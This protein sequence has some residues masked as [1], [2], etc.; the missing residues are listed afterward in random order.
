MNSSRRSIG[1]IAI[2]LICVLG[3]ALGAQA[4]APP[5]PPLPPPL[6]PPPPCD[7]T[8]LPLLGRA[9]EFGAM[10]VGANPLTLEGAAFAS[11]GNIGVGPLGQLE[12]KGAAG[13]VGYVK[14]HFGTTVTN[15]AAALGGVI[16]TDVSG[17]AAD[18]VAASN[19]FA[20]MAPT[21]VYGALTG[22]TTISGNGCINVINIMGDIDLNG[23]D[24]VRLQGTSEDY[25]V[26]N[27]FGRIRTNG[28][29][30]IVLDGM[31]PSHVLFNI[32]APG[33]DV[34]LQGDSGGNGTI[35][36][37]QG[38]IFLNGN[39]GGTGAYYVGGGDLYFLGNADYHGE[40]FGCG[41]PAC[42]DPEASGINIQTPS[43][44]PSRSTGNR[45]FFYAY[46]DP[47][48]L[49]GHLEAFRVAPNGTI[50]DE[51][52]VDAVDPVTNQLVAGRDYYWE[53]GEEL[54]LNA[55]R[56][57]YTTDGGNQE[58]FDN[59]VVDETDLNLL[60]GEI[61]AYPN[62][63]ASGVTTL[64]LLRDAI[65]QYA[66]GRDSFDE[67]GDLNF[68]ELRP[69][70]LGDIF[71]SNPVYIGEPTTLL[72]HEDG[73]AGDPGDFL[74][75]YRTRDHMV[76]A[77]ANDGIFHAF[78]AGDYY[79]PN[80]P[81]PAVFD[82]GDGSE[83]FGYIPGQLLDQIK[84][85]PR[86]ADLPGQRLAPGFVDGNIVAADAWIGDDAS[87]KTGDE[88]ATVM[89]TA[90]REGGDGYLAVDVTNPDAG[91]GDDHGPYPKLLWEFGDPDLGQSWS[92]PV[93][94]RV[95]LAAAPLSGDNCGND[96]GDGDCE[97]VWVAI[98]GG[99]YELDSDP[100]SRVNYVDDPASA[101]W[102]DTTK[103]IF[104]VRLDD[105]SILGKVEFDPT[106][107]NGPDKMVYA[108]AS[109]PAALDLDGDQF[110]DVVYIGDVGGQMWKWDI[111]ALG[112][113][114]DADNVI[115]NWDYG[116][117]FQTQPVLLSDGINSHYKSMFNPPAGALQNGELLIVVGTGMRNNVLYAGDAAVDDQNRVYV[118]RDANPTGPLA[119]SSVITEADLIDITASG[120]YI[121]T[122]A[123]KGY[124]FKGEE[125]EKFLSDPVIFAGFAIVPSYSP[126][127]WP[128]CGPG[129]ANLFLFKLY[130]ASGFWDQDAL[131]TASDRKVQIGWGIPSNPR[132]SIASD[133]SNDKIF[134]NTSNGEVLTITPP[135]RDNPGSETIYWKQNF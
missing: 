46:F 23:A 70:V 20:A 77:G 111:S 122:G 96:D 75:T 69:S 24:E 92:R 126:P 100:N 7:C 13:T 37:L 106:G 124:F 1:S 133:P 120:T 56:T 82:V 40:P 98:F 32:R 41:N 134:I 59:T 112:V 102:N 9:A 76:Y 135:V 105:G 107:V 25:Y 132:V 130:D 38:R 21:Q 78:N 2:L 110:L 88:W 15:G 128:A 18:L 51:S 66:Y 35:L 125:G 68:G 84:L 57:L 81:D 118:F 117:I 79:D 6:P 90:F 8:T 53:A 63:P 44:P 47:L 52:D 108:V 17:A 27:V 49:E 119:F 42:P 43:T 95:K 30:D 54:A 55:A 19:A 103:A 58:P 114:G 104:M 64:P 89:I 93:L 101:A 16:E 80:D 62:F 94:G 22:S 87:D 72:V 67:D 39:T 12:F 85:T 3:F 74:E 26:I 129:M 4:A 31:D 34:L 60:L 123:D 127:I 36:N 14:H 121:D 113:D 33:A 99:G 86:K 11:G 28:N 115:D 131:F 50:K 48:T 109:A 71:R 61:P 83:R 45:P 10:S 97:E 5:P 116:M 65:I 91:V 29:G 73:Y